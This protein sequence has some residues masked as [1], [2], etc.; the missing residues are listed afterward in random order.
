MDRF[1]RIK[2]ESAKR[3]ASIR[4]IKFPGNV[5][6]EWSG[7]GTGY[8]WKGAATSASEWFIYLCRLIVVP[9]EIGITPNDYFYFCSPRCRRDDREGGIGIKMATSSS[10][11]ALEPSGTSVGV[12]SSVPPSPP[13]VSDMSRITVARCDKPRDWRARKGIEVSRCSP[14]KIKVFLLALL[15]LLILLLSLSPLCGSF[16]SR[17]YLKNSLPNIA[18]TDGY[19]REEALFSIPRIPVAPCFPHREAAFVDRISLVYK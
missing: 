2:S 16:P 12:A 9:S 5:E 1:S 13:P 19:Y 14:E 17:P 15:L 18:G 11:V 8:R 3:G 10:R 4:L 7:V 6:S